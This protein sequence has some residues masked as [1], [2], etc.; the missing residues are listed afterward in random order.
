RSRSAVGCRLTSMPLARGSV[1]C[2]ASSAPAAA[3]ARAFARAPRGCR[4]ASGATPVPPRRPRGARAKA[5]VPAVAGVEFADEIQELRGGGI[6]VSRQLGDL[7]AESIEI[8]HEPLS[9]V[10]FG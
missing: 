4:G 7:I 1:L 2:S 8:C 9:R 6:E 10:N 5:G 3:G